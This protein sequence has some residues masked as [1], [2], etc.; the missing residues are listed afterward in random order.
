MSC[1]FL[2]DQSRDVQD[3]LSCEPPKIGP[4]GVVKGPSAQIVTDVFSLPLSLG[5]DR[6]SYATR[7]KS[8]IGRLLLCLRH[9]VVV[10]VTLFAASGDGQMERHT[11]TYREKQR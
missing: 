11:S 1:L 9:R 10:D 5:A 6:E 2:R 7:S 8:I 3:A 4:C